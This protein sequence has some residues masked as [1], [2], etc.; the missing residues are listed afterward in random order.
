MC[1]WN[2][3]M[4]FLATIARH[5]RR[6]ICGARQMRR[7]TRLLRRETNAAA[8]FCG[9][10]NAAADFCGERNAAA[11]FCSA[12]QMRRTDT[13]KGEKK[14]TTKTFL[15]KKVATTLMCQGFFY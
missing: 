5:L 9:E 11:D 3:G 13:E 12:R 15:H 4:P 6:Y 10:T 7:E 1:P 8:D 2:F 14:Q